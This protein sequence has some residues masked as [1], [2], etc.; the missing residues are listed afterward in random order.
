MKTK[1]IIKKQTLEHWKRCTPVIWDGLRTNEHIYFQF[2][3]FTFAYKFAFKNI[4]ICNPVEI[5]LEEFDDRNQLTFQIHAHFIQW[6][7]F[8]FSEYKN[9][10]V[11]VLEMNKNIV[12]F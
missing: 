5:V 11:S 2:P 9:K 1:K 6:V 7:C 10:I 3:I 8:S 12:S 4:H